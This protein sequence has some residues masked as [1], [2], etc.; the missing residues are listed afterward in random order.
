[1]KKP[2]IRGGATPAG[3]TDWRR[4]EGEMPGIYVDVDTSAAAFE[5]TPHYVASLAGRTHHWLTTGG[6]CIYDPLPIG[7]RI[8][9]RYFDS[10]A[11]NMTPEF[12]NEAEWHVTWIGV[13][14]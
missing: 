12:A 8:Y 14:P 7:F 4:Y 5:T 9:V 2:K 1:M 11:E 3:S 13:E 10:S 6:S